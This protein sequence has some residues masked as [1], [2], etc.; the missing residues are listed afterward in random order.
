MFIICFSLKQTSVEKRNFE[1]LSVWHFEIAVWPL[2]IE[3]FKKQSGEP[4]VK[5]FIA[6]GGFEK[7]FHE[8]RL[9]VFIAG[10]ACAQPTFLLHEVEKDNSSQH[11]LG[12]VANG[13]FIAFEN[14]YFKIGLTE[15]S[16]KVVIVQSI[17][18]EKCLAEFLYRESVRQ[19][20]RIYRTFDA[21]RF[22]SFC[23]CSASFIW[24]Q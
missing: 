12:E 11:F 13:F 22:K 3:C 24:S 14:R 5:I 2:L 9:P 7:K 6:S 8:V 19:C 16:N 17:F 4:T 10:I 15:I 18:V 20:L 1:L 21:K 23:R